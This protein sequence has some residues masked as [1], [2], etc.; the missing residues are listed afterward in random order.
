MAINAKCKNVS[1][2]VVKNKDTTPGRLRLCLR[3]PAMLT[4]GCCGGAGSWWLVRRARTTN[5]LRQSNLTILRPIAGLK[6]ILSFQCANAEQPNRLPFFF[7]SFQTRTSEVY[8]QVTSNVFLFEIPVTGEYSIKIW[9]QNILMELQ[10][11]FT[12]GRFACSLSHGR[13]QPHNHGPDHPLNARPCLPR[14]TCTG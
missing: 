14:K 8:L 1:V 2:C 7:P 3:T 5:K 9:M 4:C 13:T 12:F 11:L 6:N 10:I